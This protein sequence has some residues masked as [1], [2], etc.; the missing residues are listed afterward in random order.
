[1]NQSKE[2]TNKIKLK[3]II[4]SYCG[5]KNSEY[6]LYFLLSRNKNNKL[7]MG[8]NFKFNYLKNISKIKFNENA[9]EHCECSDG[10][11]LFAYCR[12]KDCKIYNMLFIHVL[13]YGIFDIMNEILKVQCPLCYKKSEVK[14]IGLINSKWYYKGKLNCSKQNAFEGDGITVDNQ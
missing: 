7:Q 13:G 14:N 9:P 8:L 1:M 11:N 3:Y 5:N 2:I 4:N 10:I 6:I 12:N